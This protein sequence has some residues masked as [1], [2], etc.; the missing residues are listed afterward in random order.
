MQVTNAAL[1]EQVS[2]GESTHN[3]ILSEAA[4]HKNSMCNLISF[5]T[6]ILGDKV[7]K[8]IQ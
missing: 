5:V 6:C 4:R 1:K 7:I 2:T 3:K 8:E